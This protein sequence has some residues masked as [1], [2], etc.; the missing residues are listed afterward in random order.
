MRVETVTCPGCGWVDSIEVPPGCCLTKMGES[1][2]R[3]TLGL[4]SDTAGVAIHQCAD[5]TL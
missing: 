4:Y 2:G 5:G 1:S 3:W